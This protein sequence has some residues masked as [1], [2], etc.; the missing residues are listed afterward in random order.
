MTSQKDK[1]ERISACHDLWLVWGS[2]AR[3]EYSH[4]WIDSNA[5]IYDGKIWTEAEAKA[6]IIQVIL[7]I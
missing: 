1:G 2:I 5:R 3:V 4:I 6:K 7:Q